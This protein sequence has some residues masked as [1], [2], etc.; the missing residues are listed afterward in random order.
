MNWSSAILYRVNNAITEALK[1]KYPSAL[2]TTEEKKATKPTFPTIYTSIVSM[3]EIGK[4]LDNTN[5]NAVNATFEVRVTTNDTKLNTLQ[6]ADDAMMVLKSLRCDIVMMPLV[7]EQ[8]TDRTIAVVRG[9]R[10]FG[11]GDKF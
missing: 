3:T 1:T 7:T 8:T 11:N 10:V 6:I 4:D 2:F 5:I 9:R